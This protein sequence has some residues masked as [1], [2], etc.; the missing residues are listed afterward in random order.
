ME[1]NNSSII[2]IIIF[3]PIDPLLFGFEI[4]LMLSM[5]IY[6]SAEITINKISSLYC[7]MSAAVLSLRKNDGREYL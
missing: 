3:L 7:R 6:S 2:I 1:S 5:R 4:I